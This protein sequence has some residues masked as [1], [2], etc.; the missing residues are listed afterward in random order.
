MDTATRLLRLLTLLQTRPV[1]AGETLAERLAVTTRT[2]RRDVTR[3][4]ELGYPIEA[5]AGA[6]GGYRLGAG[7]D[8]P[9]LLL[10]DDEAVAVV[11]G[12]STAV[13]AGVDGVGD[14]STRVLTKLDQV[15]PPRVRKRVG[16]LSSMTLDARSG[17]GGVFDVDPA[18]LLLIAGHCARAEELRFRYVA[19][20]GEE[21]R[22]RTE[23]YRLVRSGRRWY[24][25]AFDRDR[26]DWRS[27]R[28]D[29]MDRLVEGGERFVRGPDLP[30]AAE[31]VAN[32]VGHAPYPV[33]ARVRLPVDAETARGELSAWFGTCEDDEDGGCVLSAGGSDLSALA[34]SLAWLPWDFEVLEPQAAQDAVAALGRRLVGAAGPAAATD[35]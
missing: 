20:S 27:F 10:D 1:W 17:P 25:V 9:P 28:V 32:A 2:V 19:R 6:E 30:D 23:P 14:A 22:R 4:R 13:V 33:Q 26:R 12:L 15:L 34:A 16:E 18:K 7:G 31:Y 35:G 11:L 21:S 29:R 5:T 3:L 24:L 8:L